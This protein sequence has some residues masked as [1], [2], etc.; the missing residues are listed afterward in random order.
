MRCNTSIQAMENVQ[1]RSRSHSV[2]GELFSVGARSGFVR[3]LV[4]WQDGIGVVKVRSL[5]RFARNVES[6]TR[7][8]H[9]FA[10]R[11][12]FQARSLRLFAQP[13]EFRA[14]SLRRFARSAEFRA[15]SF[16]FEM[17]SLRL[18]AQPFEFRAR[19]RVFCCKRL[20]SSDRTLPKHNPPITQNHR[21]VTRC[22]RQGCSRPLAENATEKLHSVVQC[23]HEDIDLVMGVVE[24]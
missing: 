24:I 18:F 11:S 7:S 21:C 22:D 15:R 2:T 13:F 19:S 5:R 23:S 10:P 12:E 9:L 6:R 1:A 16:W 20:E 4:L 3:V 14:R 17:R 8:L